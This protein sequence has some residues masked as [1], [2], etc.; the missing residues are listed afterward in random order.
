M[1]YRYTA[2]WIRDKLPGQPEVG[3]ITGTGL[4]A[5]ADILQD[6]WEMPYKEVPGFAISTAPSHA[7]KLVWGTAGGKSVLLLNGRFHLYEGYSVEQVVFPVRVMACLGIRIL[8]VTN[9]SG[10]LSKELKPAQIVLLSDHINFMGVNPLTGANDDT[11]GERFPSLNNPYAPVL[12]EKFLRLAKN[13]GI[14]VGEG[15]YVGVLGPSLETRAECAMFAGWGA[16]L[17][18]MSTIPEVIVARHTGMDVLGI[19]VVTNYSNLFHD[20][21]HEQ[22]DIRRNAAKAASDLQILLTGLLKEMP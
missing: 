20:L 17:V 1:D 11:L 14:E 12:R 6:R 10:S 3:I 22:Q 13:R 7:G 19:S 4:G 16:D 5:L 2:Q 21:A 8:I 15:V 18:G 9:A